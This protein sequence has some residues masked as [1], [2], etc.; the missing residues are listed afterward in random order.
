MS[1]LRLFLYYKGESVEA[2]KGILRDPSQAIP[3]LLGVFSVG[4]AGRWDTG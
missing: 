4:S 1:R 3:I 2:L